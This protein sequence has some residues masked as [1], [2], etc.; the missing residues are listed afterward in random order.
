LS[1]G[2]QKVPF[3]PFFAK[4]GLVSFDLSL[5]WGFF[6]AQIGDT[7]TNQQQIPIHRISNFVKRTMV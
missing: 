4:V 7:L 6:F 3:D 1:R 5:K 2:K